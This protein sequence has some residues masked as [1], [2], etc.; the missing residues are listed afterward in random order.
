MTRSTGASLFTSQPP[1]RLERRS[2]VFLTGAHLTAQDLR[3]ACRVRAE[4]T[5]VILVDFF[6]VAHARTG[7]ADKL[8]SDEATVA[9]VP[10]VT[11]QSLDGAAAQ[12]RE[13]P[14]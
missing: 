6:E 5:P 2:R 13:K 10:R 12:Q 4:R 8:P 9:A 3:Q 7:T 1:L 14:R 11:K